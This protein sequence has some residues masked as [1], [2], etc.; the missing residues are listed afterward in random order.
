MTGSESPTS[1]IDRVS[2]ISSESRKNSGVK[3]TPMAEEDAVYDETAD[4][5]DDEDAEFGD[6]FDEFAEGDEDAEFGDFGDDFQEPEA[7]APPP[8]PPQTQPT[9]P[10]IVSSS[11]R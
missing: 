1:N 3:M 11:N 9:A 8:P 10:C 2:S 4:G 5:V 7:I 6:D